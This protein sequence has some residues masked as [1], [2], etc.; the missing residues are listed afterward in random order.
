[1]YLNDSL[2]YIYCTLGLQDIANVYSIQ[3]RYCHTF[4]CNV[5]PTCWQRLPYVLDNT[6]HF[7][8]QDHSHHQLPEMDPWTPPTPPTP[9]PGKVKPMVVHLHF[10][11]LPSWRFNWFQDAERRVWLALWRQLPPN[12]LL[13]GT[14]WAVI[15]GSFNCALLST[16][17][18]F[19]LSHLFSCE[20]LPLLSGCTETL[21]L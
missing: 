2:W 13:H 16:A 21:P 7:T 12:A 15:T 8:C 20:C 17:V 18:V 19:H 1:M 14:G 5:T 6:H 4:N 10:K 11:C 9:P 3:W